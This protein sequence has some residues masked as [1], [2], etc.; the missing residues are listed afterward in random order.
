MGNGNQESVSRTRSYAEEAALDNSLFTVWTLNWGVKVHP[1]FDKDKLKFS[2]IEKGKAGKGKSFDIYMDIVKYGAPC[3]EKWSNDILSPSRRFEAVLAGEKQQGEQYPKAY[4]FIT[5]VKGSKSIGFCNSKNGKYCLNATVPGTFANIPLDF[6]D[7]M[8]L[9]KNI[10]EAYRER[11]C[12]LMEIRKKAEEESARYYKDS[13]AEAFDKEQRMEQYEEEPVDM[14]NAGPV[15]SGVKSSP[16]PDSLPKNNPQPEKI[17]VVVTKVAK[18]EDGSLVIYAK[19]ESG[20]ILLYA[21]RNIVAQPLWKQF[22]E[23]TQQKD[24]TTARFNAIACT[25]TYNY[26]ITGFA[27]A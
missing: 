21:N 7:I 4:K 6:G 8:M 14:Q 15:P 18:Q 24:E 19:N 3:W 9:A 1:W 27:V 17:N 5:G 23:V 16:Q 2:F 20:N 12:Q 26:N 13:D 25:G 22:I 11:R 10:D